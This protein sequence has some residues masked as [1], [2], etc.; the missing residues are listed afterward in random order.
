MLKFEGIGNLI[1]E[2]HN[3]V[4]RNKSFNFAQ[5]FAQITIF[6]CVY[7]NHMNC[8]E[9]NIEVFSMGMILNHWGRVTHICVSY[10]NIIGSVNDWSTGR[11]PAII[12]TNA[13]IVLIWTIRTNFNVDWNISETG[14]E[15]RLHWQH[16]PY[17]LI[18]IIRVIPPPPPP[19]KKKKK[20]KKRK[21]NSQNI[22]KMNSDMYT[23]IL[24][25]P[26][27]N[28][29]LHTILGSILLLTDK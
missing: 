9:K 18:I 7:S 26:F 24:T 28:I 15:L 14:Y 22:L 4:N 23:F 6:C 29:P 8:N 12:W 3:C 11:R 25:Y 2:G 27:L 20:E 13:G 1:I 21:E 5:H 17:H 19:K 16:F 10:L